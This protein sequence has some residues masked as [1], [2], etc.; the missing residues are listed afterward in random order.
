MLEHHRCFPGPLPAPPDASSSTAPA[1]MTQDNTGADDKAGSMADQESGSR[2]GGVAVQGEKVGDKLA[3]EV[4]V[5]CI[6]RRKSEGV[7]AT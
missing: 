2:T 6:G 3:V 5:V 4:L 7:V 1:P